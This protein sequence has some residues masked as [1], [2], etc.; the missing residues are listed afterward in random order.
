MDN[1]FNTDILLA[2]SKL[3]GEL[4][5]IEHTKGVIN[6]THYVLSYFF[7]KSN[8]LNDNIVSYSKLEKGC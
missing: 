5:L 7:K 4:S 6:I 3:N 1:S 2:K 8:L